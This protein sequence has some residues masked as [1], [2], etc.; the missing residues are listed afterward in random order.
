MPDLQRG[1]DKRDITNP[2]LCSN[3]HVASKRHSPLPVR[4]K[5]SLLTWS[6]MLKRISFWVHA[7]FIW[8]RK[9]SRHFEPYL[10][11]TCPSRNTK[12]HN[13]YGAGSCCHHGCWCSGSSLFLLHLCFITVCR[14]QLDLVARCDVSMMS[15]GHDVV[16]CRCHIK[17]SSL[18]C[19]LSL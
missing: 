4:C 13:R 11:C 3:C 15:T 1:C 17:I 2:H 6:A 5:S 7:S 14:G 16:C 12:C 9:K 8:C 18:V 19:S 10:S